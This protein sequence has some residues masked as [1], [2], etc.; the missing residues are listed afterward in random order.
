MTR[1]DNTSGDG[2]GT[3]DPV[4]AGKLTAD[5]SQVM[6]VLAGGGVA[7]LPLDV[8]YAIVAMGDDGIRR[9][10][11]AKNR[12]YE[13]PSG[14]FGNW[15]LSSEVHV[16]DADRHAM[17]HGIIETDGLP[18]SV[19]APFRADHPIFA[20]VPPFVLQNSTKAGTLDML[21]NAGQVH[22]E[23]AR[24]AVARGRPVFGSS[25]NTS[26]AGSKYRYG[27]IEDRVRD[28]ADIHLDYGTS[29]YANPNGR[30][31]TIVDFRDFHVVRVGVCFDTLAGIFRERYD[32]TL[33]VDER[34]AQ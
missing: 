23:I 33:T 24:Q 31:S 18:F 16:M 20:E 3:G 34:T 29:K 26:L 28:A 19:V 27:D 15:Q 9:I 17:V 5:V 2:R 14:M 21:L 25:A 32:V 22:D 11:S 10:F 30:S 8:A 12:S 6:D 1:T 7:I 4:P 13:K